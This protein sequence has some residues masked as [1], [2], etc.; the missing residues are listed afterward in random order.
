[1]LISR[2]PHHAHPKTRPDD[3]RGTSRGFL[4][5]KRSGLHT[6]L[7]N[8]KSFGPFAG[9]LL[10]SLS[11]KSVLVHVGSN[12]QFV[13]KVLEDMEISV[14]LGFDNAARGDRIMVIG[15]KGRVAVAFFQCIVQGRLGVR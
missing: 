1:M 9:S 8:R 12:L 14:Q 13:I 4:A 2:R 10:H 3:K 11:P 15:D 6:R 5:A 7:I